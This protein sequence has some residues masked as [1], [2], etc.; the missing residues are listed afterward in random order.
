MNS[1]LFCIASLG[2]GERLYNGV[3]KKPQTVEITLQANSFTV[4]CR[5]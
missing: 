4:L 1:K 5:Y 3:Y 2:H